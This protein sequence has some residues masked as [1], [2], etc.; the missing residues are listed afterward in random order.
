[1]NGPNEFKVQLNA[2]A[3]GEITDMS[4]QSLHVKGVSQ[5]VEAGATIEDIRTAEIL[6]AL[7]RY[8]KDRRC[9]PGFEVVVE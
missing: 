5:L 3:I 7:E 2:L 6:I 8:M 4:E 1:M 9:D